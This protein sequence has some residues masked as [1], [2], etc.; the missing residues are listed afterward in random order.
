MYKDVSGAEA[1]AP[2]ILGQEL[3]CVNA[4][5]ALAPKPY[6]VKSVLHRQAV[7]LLCGPSNTGKSSVVASLAAHLALG[8]TLAGLRVKRVPVLFVGAE[9]PEGIRDRAHLILAQACE[10][11]AP[12]FILPRALNLLDSREVGLFLRDLD[13]TFP[14]NP[15][16]GVFIV[17]DTLNLCIGDGDENSSRDMGKAVS[18][19]QRIAQAKG[20]HV[21]LVHH[22][23][24]QDHSRPRGSTA[25]RANVDTLLILKKAEGRSGCDLVFLHQD[26]QRAMRKGGSV[27]FELSAVEAG[28]DEDGDPF[29]VPCALPVAQAEPEPEGSQG[30]SR[31]P[32]LA[33]RR[34]QDLLDLMRGL[35]K[36]KPT[37]WH[38]PQGIA[39]AAGDGPSFAACRDN[40]DSL[41][42]AVKRALDGLVKSGAVVQG[43]AGYRLA[44]PD[45]ATGEAA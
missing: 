15:G 1:N 26:K 40:G 23:G 30:G 18:S 27:G 31:R 38:P 21:M 29:T 9:D 36:G 33:E 8:K 43:K 45:G 12:F 25:L 28:T 14:I 16:D 41:R 35:A 34:A 10:A 20:G 6:L 37:A 13:Q 4:K 7:S 17:I 19:A 5:G 3:L 22:T 42:K 24:V 44:A 32:V 2:K 39:A 11:P